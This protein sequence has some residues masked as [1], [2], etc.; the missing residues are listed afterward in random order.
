ML[1][2]IREV[3]MITTESDQAA[4]KE[5]LGSGESIGMNICYEVQ[6][7]PEGLAQ[8]FLIGSNFTGSDPVALILGDNIF[9]GMGL[10][11]DLINSTNPSGAFI[12]GY[13]VKNPE[14]YGVAEVDENRKVI[15][16]E[17]KPQFPKSS[18]AIP[19][20]YFFDNTVSQ[21]ANLVK[22]SPRGELEIT[23]ILEQYKESDNLTLKYLA[24]GTSWMDCGT[25]ESLND[26]SNYIRIIE[27]R[28]GF[29]IG[30]VEEI[31]HRN[32]WISEIDL[33]ILASRYGSNEYGR[34]L[35]QLIK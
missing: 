8:A 1:A 10:G 31:A 5:L 12:F 19:G 16:I 14:R 30:C 33:K 24:R 23:S 15:S 17:E 35:E 9:H 20:L 7:K 13:S 6:P 4:F 21:K 34:Y 22:K 3:L 18:L 29:K 25:A 27:Q 28:Q 26:A 2:G 11:R 32:G